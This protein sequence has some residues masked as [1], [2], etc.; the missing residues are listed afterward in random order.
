MHLPGAKHTRRAKI[1]SGCIYIL[2]QYGSLYHSSTILLF[3]RFSSPCT[4]NKRVFFP[5]CVVTVMAATASQ[6]YTLQITIICST[7]F[8]MELC[9]HIPTRPPFFSLS[10]TYSIQ[11]SLLLLVVLARV[12]DTQDFFYAIFS[13]FNLLSNSNSIL[14][15][16]FT[17][18]NLLFLLTLMG[19]KQLPSI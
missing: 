14:C 7:D 12:I 17:L 9:H 16:S 2:Q 3:F 6:E 19:K 4:Y 11:S 18:M 15:H 13:V 10:L 8:L 1:N 5:S